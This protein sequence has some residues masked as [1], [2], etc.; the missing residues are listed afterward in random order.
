MQKP[1]TVCRDGDRG[2]LISLSSS[3]GAEVCGLGVDSSQDTPHA[4]LL[5]GQSLSTPVT[6]AFPPTATGLSLEGASQKPRSTCGSA[7]CSPTRSTRGN[8]PPPCAQSFLPR[9]GEARRGLHAAGAAPGQE[10][11]R[12][13]WPR[14]RSSSVSPATVNYTTWP[15][16][17]LCWP[18]PLLLVHLAAPVPDWDPG[19]KGATGRPGEVGPPGVSGARDQR[20]AAGARAPPAAAF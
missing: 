5:L 9:A 13:S 15:L 6:R 3:S 10:G 20:Q 11:H 14:S 19:R 4:L 18:E 1:V 12:A 2:S 17:N 7:T 8:T 16:Y